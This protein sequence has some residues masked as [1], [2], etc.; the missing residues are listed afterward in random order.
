MAGGRD[1]RLGE[2]DRAVEHVARDFE[3]GRAGGA[4][5]GLAERHAHHVGDARG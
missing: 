3:E 5:H 2:L 1:T 4:V